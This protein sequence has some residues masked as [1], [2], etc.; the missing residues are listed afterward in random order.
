MGASTGTT[1]NGG[2]LSST[3]GA[4]GRC[5]PILPVVGDCDGINCSHCGDP[6][7]TP[8]N[9]SASPDGINT[10]TAIHLA[11]DGQMYE[12]EY[13]YWTVSTEAVTVGYYGDSTA[14][15]SGIGVTPLSCSWLGVFKLL[16]PCAAFVYFHDTGELIGGAIDETSGFEYVEIRKTDDTTLR[17]RAWDCYVGSCNIAI[18]KFYGEVATASG[19][20]YITAT[21]PNQLISSDIN[22]V[23]TVDGRDYIVGGFGGVIRIRP[24][25]PP[26]GFPATVTLDFSALVDDDCAAPGNT[27]CSTDPVTSVTLN[28]TSDS[29]GPD[30]A[31]TYETKAICLNVGGTN[32]NATAS[33]VWAGKWYATAT[34]SSGTIRQGSTGSVMSNVIG[35]GLT[36]SDLSGCATGNIGVS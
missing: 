30:G 33:Y 16:P 8:G 36:T 14:I 13:E 27:T 25:A 7:H 10:A 4:R 1:P 15:N 24:C 11:S 23:K 2:N 3:L 32:Y 31:C 28:K 34:G 17:I 9:F 5:G 12:I 22:T 19:D 20:C 35:D 18:L 6:N 29:G 26:S 21:V